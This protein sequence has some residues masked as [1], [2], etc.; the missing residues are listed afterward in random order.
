MT[1]KTLA[2]VILP[3][4]SALSCSA[5]WDTDKA[6]EKAGDVLALALPLTA[7]TA[8]YTMD[9]QD[10]RYQFLLSYGSTFALTQVLKRTVQK[11]RPDG[12]NNLSFPSGHT[13]SAFSG[14]SFLAKRYGWDIGIPAYIAASFTGFSRVHA[15]KHDWIDVTA[16]AILAIG[17]NQLFVDKPDMNVA[18]LPIKDGFQLSLSYRF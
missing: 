4:I 17:M 12:S 13:S 9:D 18:A 2:S 11:E 14:A 7:F 6:I 3:F 1:R 10:G 5:D 15:D 16:G 8:S